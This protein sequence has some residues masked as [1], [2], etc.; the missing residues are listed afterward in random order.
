M[1]IVNAHKSRGGFTLVELLVVIAIIGV[2]VGLLLP[3]VQAAREAARR[4]SCSNNFKQIGLSLHNYHAAYN[5]LPPNGTGPLYAAQ[6]GLS[7]NVGLIPFMEQQGLWEMMSNPLMP[8]AGETPTDAMSTGQWPP[9]GPRPYVDLNEYDPYQMQTP[10]LRCPSDPGMSPL[11]TGMTNYAFC[12][13]DTSL[14]VGYPPS[15]QWADRG[16]FRGLFM[17]HTPRKF[18]D[19]LD[20]LSNTIAMAEIKT[21]MGDRSV[22]G[23]VVDRTYFPNDDSMGSDLTVCTDVIDPQRPQFI[24]Q[25][26]TLWNSGGTSRG[27]RW[28]NCHLMIT[29]MNTIL[30]PNSPTCAMQWGTSWQS[31]VFS[32][33]SHHQGG[34]HVLLADGAVRFVTD[35][36]DAGNRQANSISKNY[37][38]VGQASPYGLWGALGSIAAK[39]TIEGFE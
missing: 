36:I 34:V 29:G 27:G 10:T 4:M 7:A 25:S 17:R 9:F 15:S 21:D 11:G 20:G 23:S 30:P 28:W 14:R 19:V 13:G 39:E 8:E 22:G 18:R 37:N 2:L 16:A 5:R 35:S 38:N 26:V 3:A 33:A 1:R 31:G 24:E 32:S 12:H 6:R